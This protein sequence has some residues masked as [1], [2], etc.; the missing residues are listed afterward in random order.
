MSDYKIIATDN[1]PSPSSSINIT[2]MPF[3]GRIIR[4]PWFL[5]SIN[6]LSVALLMLGIFL[7][8]FTENKKTGLTVLLFWGVFWPLLTC[9]LT[10]SLGVVYCAI[11]P[12]GTIGRWLT[13][14]GLKKRYPRHL[15]GAW[16]SIALM[17]FGYWFFAYSMPGLFGSSPFNTA[18]YFLIFTVMAVI[19][20]LLYADMA[21][22]KYVCPLGRVIT[23]HGK[24]GGLTVKSKQSDCQSCK[25]FSCAKVCPYHLSP[26]NFEKNNNTES[27]TLC[28][29]CVYECSSMD[30]HW[31]RPGK[32]IVKSM[33]RTDPHDY[34]VILVIFA[35]AGVGIQ[36]LHGL[37][38]TG[39]RNYL[40]WNLLGA[41]ASHSFDV[42]AKAF[43]FSGMFAL[44]FALIT[45]FLSAF[46]AVRLA[47]KSSPELKANIGFDLAYALTPIA[48]LGL[49]PHSVSMFTT[50]YAHHLVNEFGAL[51]GL[52]WHIEPLAQRGDA[53]LKWLNILPWFG[54]LWGMRILWKRSLLWSVSSKSRWKTGILLAIPIWYYLLI[55]L[56]KV[57]AL[58][59]L[60][61]PAHH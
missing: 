60:P 8:L 11:C 5:R 23:T 39:L 54:I 25:D 2:A 1:Q 36:F 32:A 28:L 57:A 51:F 35:I 10:P 17:V 33:K 40:P 18:W 3:I 46:L 14:F 19:V 26:F 47:K 52:A 55:M 41:W 22:C 9:V 44:I 58:M 15:K 37:Q 34:W 48:I 43:N 4:N 45:T 6:I 50:N 31:Q 12:H 53:W 7:G 56:M 42:S 27:C 24:L 49:I 21:Y 16:I 29:E 59:L 61:M 13:K 20:F 38:H 30:L